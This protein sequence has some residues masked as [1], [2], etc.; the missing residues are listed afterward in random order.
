MP[1]PKVIKKEWYPILAPKIF[2]N[3]VLG[4]TPVYDPQQMIGKSMT[5]NLMNLTND[6]KRQ[7]ININFKV[8]DVQNGKALANVVGYYMVQSSIRRLI[9][10]NIEKIIMSFPCKT[11]D[12]KNLQ[13]KPLLI[14][15]SAT[16][17]SVATKMRKNAQD[18]LVK[19]ISAI[20]YENLVNDLVNHKLQSSLKKDMNKIYPL[21]VCE[22]KS[23]EIVSLEKKVE[24]EGEPKTGKKQKVV[25]NVEEST[26]EEKIEKP[27]ESKEEKPKKAEESKE[28]E[29][30]E[31]KVDARKSEISGTHS[32]GEKKEEL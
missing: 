3:A 19:Y 13:V 22:I 5:K 24:V 30:K 8:V 21:R 17:G 31:T 26:K 32:M 10:R 20:S 7:N 14:T 18:F 23:M 4:E 28:I 2:Q 1:K 16:T 12:N 27:E 25:K 11:S 9:R 29:K 15:R 6:V